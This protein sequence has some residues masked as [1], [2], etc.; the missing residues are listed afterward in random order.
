[1]FNW[2]RTLGKTIEI[3]SIAGL[4]LGIATDLPPLV[5]TIVKHFW[6]NQPQPPSIVEVNASEVVCKN[7]NIRVQLIRRGARRVYIGIH[8][9][10][11]ERIEMFQD[12]DGK[13]RNK[14]HTYEILGKTSKQVIIRVTFPKKSGKKSYT[15][16]L[17]C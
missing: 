3:V 5:N 7:G 6:P 9:L 13:F 4:F 15:V 1:M 14:G 11:R 2:R 10:K 8:V 16:K 12:L 17:Y